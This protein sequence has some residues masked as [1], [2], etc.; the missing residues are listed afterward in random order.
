MRDWKS[1]ARN[2]PD[3][4]GV[5]V[6]LDKFNR[7]VY[8]GKAKSLRKR[9][10]SY[11][12]EA[13]TD[14]RRF[15]RKLP[16]ILHDIQTHVTN[17]EKEALLLEREL[18]R[19]HSPRFNV[20]WKDDKQ[21]LCL[22]IDP[23]HEFPWVQMVRKMKKDGARY[24]GP[25]HSSNAARKTLKVVNRHF[26]LRTCSDREMAQR[27]RPCLEYQIGR[28][29]AP[30]VFDIDK[31]AY[32]A[33]VADALLFLE[34][35]EPALLKK[36][37]AKMWSASEMFDYELAAQLR[38]QIQAIR[39]TLQRQNTVMSSMRDQDV[40]GFFR[41]DT[42]HCIV[43]MEVREGRVRDFHRTHFK[44]SSLESS[45]VLQTFVLQYYLDHQA[46][47]H[48]V[49]LPFQCRDLETIQELL[50]EQRG[51]KVV[52]SIPQRGERVRLVELAN[53]NAK[54]G[55]EE[56]RKKDQSKASTLEGLKTKLHLR[57]LPEKIECFDVSHFQ[58]DEI[59][60]S[61]VTFVNSY[62]EK[63][64]YRR[65]R[66]KGMDNQNDFASMYQVVSRRTIRGL[67]ENDLPHLMVIDGGK[68]QLG[69]ARAALRD[70]NVEHIDIVG[71]A[72]ERGLDAAKK[73]E[74]VFR[75]GAKAAIMIPTSAPEMRLLMAIRDE[76][77]RF[78]VTFNQARRAKKTLRSE[79]DD[80]PGVGPK[81]RRALLTAFGSPERVANASLE[82]LL[83]VEGFGHHQAMRVFDHYRGNG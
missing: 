70:L 65:Y 76:A 64:S 14:Y 49:V 81:R 61:K 34:G 26:R 53:E 37:E 52:V 72:K 80:I 1:F 16:T 51:K 44:A 54:H 2:L 5:Y 38:D 18:I 60:A 36:L 9:V 11:F 46:M 8:V 23:K 82:E 66:I 71:L 69:A 41:D 27:N 78:A 13:T 62:P 3:Q 77:H 40:I 28:C 50:T 58:G 33:D 32:E 20:I 55:F 75:E 74:R 79:L 12:G 25:F 21:Y 7:A 10:Q 63:R 39:K 42:Q 17:S 24:F 22:R 57:H 59:V 48:E 73:P 6:F 31:E 29:P 45:D 43:I 19:K 35:Q 68:G 30:C 4:P 56:R 15:I 67:E 47:P 83:T